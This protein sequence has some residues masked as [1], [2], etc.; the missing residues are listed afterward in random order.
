MRES[1][2]RYKFHNENPR[3]LLRASDCVIRA[4]AFTLDK[5]WDD[6]LRYLTDIALEIKNTPTSDQTFEEYLKRQGYIKKKQLRKDDGT[7]Y[8]VEEFAEL[9]GQGT[10]IVRV[11]GHLTSVKNGYVYDTWDCTYKTTGNYWEIK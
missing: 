9:K 2:G 7:K 6:V 8:T 5:K 3:N 11:A 1:K 10:F 4:L